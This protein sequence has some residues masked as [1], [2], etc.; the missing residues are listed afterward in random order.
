MEHRL[1][2]EDGFFPSDSVLK[3]M[4][5]ESVGLLGGGRALLMQLAHPLVACGVSAHSDFHAD[6]LGRLDRTVN[7]MLALIAGTRSQAEAALRRFHTV[8]AP[9]HG[10]APVAAGSFAN[11]LTYSAR[12]PALQLWVH[13]T[14]IDTTL[15]TYEHFVKPLA[16]NERA[17]FYADALRFADLIGIPSTI[18]PPTLEKFHAYMCSML[19]GDTLTVTDAARALAPLVLAPTVWIVPRTCAA[20]VRF[21]TAGLLPDRLREAYGFVWDA[22]RQARLDMLS[23]ASRTLLPFAPHSLRHLSVAGRTGFVSWALRH[24]P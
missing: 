9:I 10:R 6:P 22:R 16:S 21:V 19:S 20:L 13:A 23:D 2:A 3:R 8:H 17:R 1:T 24:T 5:R 14:L 12:D 7:L 15:I 11:G 18:V 4:A